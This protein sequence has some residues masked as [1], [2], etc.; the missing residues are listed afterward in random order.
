MEYF[1]GNPFVMNILQTATHCKPM[2]TNALQPRY[3]GGGGGGVFGKSARSDSSLIAA[4]AVGESQYKLEE[5][6]YN[7]CQRHHRKQE[8]N[9]RNK[10]GSYEN[11]RCTGPHG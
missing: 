3:P 11:N 9:H 6:F 7:V 10:A 8:R 4:S 2:N 5:H 1:A